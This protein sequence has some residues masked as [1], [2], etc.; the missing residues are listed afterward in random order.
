MKWI[1]FA[2]TL[3]I[4]GSTAQL[5][6]AQTSETA[7]VQG[8]RNLGS[9]WQSLSASS[10]VLVVECKNNTFMGIRSIKG[11][12]VSVDLQKTNSVMSPYLGIVRFTGRFYVNGTGPDKACFE[13]FNEAKQN[14]DFFGNERDYQFEAYYQV[15]GNELQL[16]GG[17]E[18]FT[19]AL[20]RQGRP[21]LEAGSAWHK[22][23]RYPL[24]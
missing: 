5:S 11:G 16:S 7:I 10:N 17:N 9:L 18:V 1:V 13:T 21:Q 14:T 4:T 22:A 8:M 12:V 19:N 20:L 15:N 6:A 2:C 3:L 24:K 23:F